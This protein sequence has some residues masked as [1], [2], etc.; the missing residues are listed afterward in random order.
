MQLI[1]K[2]KFHIY[3]THEMLERFLSIDAME[4]GVITQAQKLVVNSVDYNEDS[5]EL[6]VIVDLFQA[7]IN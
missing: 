3:V 1:E 2:E 4:L 5:E 6:E 7:N